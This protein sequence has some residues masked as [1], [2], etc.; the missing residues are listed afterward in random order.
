MHETFLAPAKVNLTL[1]VLARRDDGYHLLAML[2]QRIALYDRIGITLTATPGVEVDCPGLE[3]SPGGENIAAGAARRMLELSGASGGVKLTIEKSIPAA[4]GLGGGSSDAATVLAGLNQM[5]GVDLLP[6]QLRQEG[7]RLGADVPFFLF[8]APAMA[9]GVGEVLERAPLLPP[10]WYVLV[11][12]GIEVPTAWAFQNLGLTS[13]RDEAKLPGFFATADDLAQ[14]LRNDLEA[15]TIARH[16]LLGEIKQQLCEV[17][18]R[19]A[20]MS[21]SGATLFG[22]FAGEEEAQRAAE[23]LSGA[24]GWWVAVV[25]PVTSEQVLLRA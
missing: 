21:G 3:L 16:P 18:A 5:L 1:Q 22:V 4:A 12:P 24:S 6:S 13:L 11:N 17:G 14:A 25:P 2:M 7:L 15:V 20:L 10:H 23:A 8:G 19:G 9:R